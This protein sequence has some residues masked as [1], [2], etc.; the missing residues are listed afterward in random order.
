MI[1]PRVRSVKDARADFEELKHVDDGDLHWDD[2]TH[3]GMR[4]WT[5]PEDQLVAHFSI[6]IP[7]T[8]ED[9]PRLS[10][11]LGLPVGSHLILSAASYGDDFEQALDAAT[12]EKFSITLI[13]HPSEPAEVLAVPEPDPAPAVTVS[14][15]ISERD[16]DFFCV[17]SFRFD[18]EHFRGCL[19]TYAPGKSAVDDE[20]D[21]HWQM[22]YVVDREGGYANV[23]LMTAFLTAHGYPYELVGAAQ[24]DGSEWW[25][26][27]DFKTASWR[28][29]DTQ[30]EV[31]ARLAKEHAEASGDELLKTYLMP[32]ADKTKEPEDG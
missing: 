24:D 31:K 3:A 17:S 15:T 1:T 30:D 16:F 27:T 4:I 5:S 12:D 11:H 29:S 23:M 26:L 7:L 9:A 2:G 18:A 8:A 25:V 13:E 22:A 32:S 21:S 10:E 14:L 28:K 19:E 20:V 6:G